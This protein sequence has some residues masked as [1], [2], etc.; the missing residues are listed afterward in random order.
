MASSNDHLKTSETVFKLPPHSLEAEQSV[1][2]GLMLSGDVI[3]DVVT[4]I[5]A[6]DF[7]TKQ[8]QVIFE[9]IIELSRQNKP[10]DLVAVAARL[11]STGNLETAG[12]KDYL[13]ELAK[14]TPSA[15]NI[16]YYA[17][18]VRDKSILRSLIQASNEVS[19]TAYFPQ[20]KE[21]REIL[22]IAESKIMQIAEHGEGKERQYK[23][24]DILL[25]AAINKI[26]ELF[27]T[28]GSITGEETHLTEFDEITAGLQKGD[29]IIVAGRPS[30][31]KTTFSMNMAENIATK[32]S[33]PVAVFSMEMP[34]ESLAMRM[35]SSIGKIDAGRM[36]T[37]KLQQED[38]PKLNAAINILSKAKVYIDDT[39]AL[40]ITELRA[41]AR[42]IDKDI[43]DLQRKEAMEAGVENPESKVTGLGLIVVDYLQLMRGS[44]NAENRVNE[45]SEISRGLK[46]LAKELN[47]PVIAL[48]QLNRSLEQRPNKRPVM[49][50]LRESGAIEQDA[51]L[52]IFIYRDEVY[53]KDTDD[54]GTAEII[55]GKH[56]NGSL[57]TVRLTFMGEYTRFE[58]HAA[59]DVHDG[60]Y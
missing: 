40:M 51:D 60:S 45:I 42:R 22:D 15:A 46:A 4:L 53:N 36:R 30:M 13:T 18:L 14:N 47:I 54:K 55:I 6:K 23:T 37:G 31:G 32:N 26:D 28:E 16:L 49:S 35:I 20:G 29:L 11:A 41:R 21:V 33:T 39:P 10:Y 25:E 24:M 59:F 9:S 27:N 1:L 5:N 44:V 2:G 8:H 17:S 57:G 12:D 56:R 7:Y 3:D 50:D 38:W 48:S 58:N 34:G 19:E 43:R 52:I